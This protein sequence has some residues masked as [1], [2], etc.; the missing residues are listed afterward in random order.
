MTEFPLIDILNSNSQSF[1]DTLKSNLRSSNDDDTTDTTFN[2][3]RCLFRTAA[4][5]L[6]LELKNELQQ[7]SDNDNS[8][9]CS[10]DIQSHTLQ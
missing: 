8:I 1:D 3:V 5:A 6:D 7:Q 10:D 4:Q 9:N 2:N